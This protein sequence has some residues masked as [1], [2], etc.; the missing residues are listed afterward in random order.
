[1]QLERTQLDLS[2]FRAAE[3]HNVGYFLFCFASERRTSLELDGKVS[4]WTGWSNPSPLNKM[5]WA[6][7]VRNYICYMGLHKICS[8]VR[9]LVISRDF[10]DIRERCY[11]RVVT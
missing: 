4:N 10:G 9:Y 7:E 1:M 11:M 3:R 8:M 2:S 6:S 5:V